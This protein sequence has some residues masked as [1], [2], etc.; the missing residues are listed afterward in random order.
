MSAR[1]KVRSGLG[2]RDPGLDEM[3][4]RRREALAAMEKLPVAEI[5]KIAVRA[6]IYTEDGQ[7]TPQYRLDAEPSASRPSD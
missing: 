6:G 7:L 3:T 1:A 5:F 2:I 4:R